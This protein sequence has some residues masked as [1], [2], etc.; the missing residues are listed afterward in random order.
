LA[1]LQEGDLLLALD[2]TAILGTDDLVRLLGA[3]R[4][5]RDVSVSFIRDGKPERTSLRPVERTVNN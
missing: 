2:G 3:E 5:G 1:G 4:I